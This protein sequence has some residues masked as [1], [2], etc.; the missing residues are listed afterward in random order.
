MPSRSEIW[1]STITV[2]S[3]LSTHTGYVFESRC[4]PFGSGSFC[5]D[6]G[7]LPGTSSR[8]SLLRLAVG[9]ELASSC[10]KQNLSKPAAT[11]QIDATTHGISFRTRYD[12]ISLPFEGS[13]PRPSRDRPVR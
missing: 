11:I 3:F 5:G 4:A 10:A 12:F 13:D 1:P 6:G 2:P 8:T 7:S 9:E